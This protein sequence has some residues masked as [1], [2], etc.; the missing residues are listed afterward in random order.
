M[1]FNQSLQAIAASLALLSLSDPAAA[2]AR[3]NIADDPK[4]SNCTEGCLDAGYAWAKAN[5]ATDAADCEASNEEFA[6]GCRNYVLESL[7][8]VPAEGPEDAQG[9]ST[10][11]TWID[12]SSE[13]AD[14]AAEADDPADPPQG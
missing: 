13:N 12:A 1:N 2:Q 14:E 5:H 9:S 6:A 7:P 11:D 3:S 8:A 4:S 10:V